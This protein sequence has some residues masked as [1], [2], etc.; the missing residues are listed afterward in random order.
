MTLEARQSEALG[1][2]A[3]TGEGR[4]TMNE[5]RQNGRPVA[6]ITA[7]LILLGAHFAKH[8]R[9]DDFQMRWI[10]GQRQMDIVA[11]ESPVRRSAQMIFDIARTFYIV[12]LERT[13]LE[14]VENRTQRFA[15]NIAENIQTAAMGHAKHD[16][17]HAELSATLDDLFKRGNHSF[18]AVESEPLRAGVFDVAEFLEKLRID[19]LIQNRTL[20][21]HREVDALLLALD[22]LLQPRLLRRISDVHEL[23]ADLAAIGAP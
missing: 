21:R 23:I 19:Q 6:R 15:E 11:V 4:I 17:D 22:A 7:V 8:N 10:G 3:L 1:H 20:A 9:I 5:Q 14:L 12:R 2:H 16:L 18:A 13:T